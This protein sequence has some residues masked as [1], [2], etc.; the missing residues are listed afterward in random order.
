MKILVIED[1]E[2][3]RKSLK[4]I[5][6][7]KGHTVFLYKDGD[8]AQK[9]AENLKPDLTISDHDLGEGDKGLHIAS[10]LRKKGFEVIMMSGN[11]GIRN[12]S[13]DLGI[14]FVLKP[15]LNKLFGMVDEFS[16]KMAI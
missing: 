1:E 2:L 3:L 13:W 10:N 8:G 14:P 12:A 6:S 11:E 4:M 16:K 15:D 9:Y 7:G 5:L